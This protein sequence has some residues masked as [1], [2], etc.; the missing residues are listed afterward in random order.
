MRTPPPPAPPQHRPNGMP[1]L[2]AA[3]VTGAWWLYAIMFSALY[4]VV[5]LSIGLLGHRDLGIVFTIVSSVIAGVL[6]GAING[7]VTSASVRDKW[8][9]TRPYPAGK[10]PEIARA[11]GGGP[12]PADADIRDAAIRLELYRAARLHGRRYVSR[13]GASAFALGAAWIAVAFTP[14]FWITS[15][16]FLGL[17]GYMWLLPGRLIRRVDHLDAESSSAQGA[18]HTGQRRE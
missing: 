10:E 13:I 11:L 17:L 2:P 6:S 12:G 7:S 3:Y 14:W 4:A 9:A 15:A 5:Q 8:A 18:L 1:S 16:S